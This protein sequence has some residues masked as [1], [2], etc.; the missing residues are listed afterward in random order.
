MHYYDVVS[1]Y[2]SGN[3][4]DKYSVSFKQFYNPTIEENLDEQFIGVVKCDVEL[5]NNLYVPV[6]PESKDG[7][8]LFNLNLMSGTW[9]SVKLKKLLKLVM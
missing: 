7:K 8:L 2:P 1:L 6:L 9:C 4:L 5:P 3:A